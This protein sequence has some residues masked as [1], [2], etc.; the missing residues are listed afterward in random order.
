MP[1][2]SFEPFLPTINKLS[3]QLFRHEDLQIAIM[4]NKKKLTRSE[5]AAKKTE[6][7][8]GANDARAPW[9]DDGSSSRS[10]G[11][12]DRVGELQGMKTECFSQ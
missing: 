3:S 1:H 10:A 11:G 5:R 8:K 2:S 12:D 4:T 6:L 9:E 7:A